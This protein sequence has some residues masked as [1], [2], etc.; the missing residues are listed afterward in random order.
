MHCQTSCFINFLTSGRLGLFG[1]RNQPSGIPTWHQD[2]WGLICDYK[3]ALDYWPYAFCRTMGYTGAKQVA[4]LEDVPYMD[5]HDIATM[6]VNFLHVACPKFADNFS[7]CRQD[8]GTGP[9]SKTNGSIYVVCE[10]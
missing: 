6:E 10:F 4:Y 2:S 8:F 7:F 3:V 9:C 1:N 5:F